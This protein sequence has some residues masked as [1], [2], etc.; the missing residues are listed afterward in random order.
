MTANDIFEEILKDP[1]LV[2]KYS[3]D[4]ESLK[5]VKL[6]DPKSEYEILEIVKL[7]I[8]GV[9]NGTPDNSVNS[10]IKN[11]FNL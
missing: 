1:I 6:H 11:L 3:I 10:Q 7:V 2:E 8:Q 4:R 9:E 5:K